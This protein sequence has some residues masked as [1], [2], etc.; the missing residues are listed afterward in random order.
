MDVRRSSIK[1]TSFLAD[2]IPGIDFWTGS[3]HIDP[4]YTL[5]DEPA[6]KI[7]RA[8]QSSY[9]FNSAVYFLLLVMHGEVSHFQLCELKFEE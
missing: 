6:I 2:I 9:R 8:V 4:D 1:I 3:L 5:S 7:L